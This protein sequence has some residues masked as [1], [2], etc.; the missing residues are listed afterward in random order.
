[1][2]GKA[3]SLVRIEPVEKIPVFCMFAVYERDCKE[4]DA[5]RIVIILSEDKKQTIR[6]HFPNAD[7][8]A[9]IPNPEVFIEDIRHS[10]G[11]E[12]KAENVHYFHIDKEFDTKDGQTAIYMEY[13]RDLMQDVPPVK[14][15]K[16]TRYTFYEDYAFRVLFCKD[17]FFEKEQEYRIVLPNEVIEGGKSYLVKFSDKYEI[18]DFPFFFEN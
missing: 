13:I 17:V 16:G 11:T 6:E 5:G 14:C 10:I 2:C 9:I 1:M 4:D 7:A 8:V 12:V 15:D 3:N 18:Y